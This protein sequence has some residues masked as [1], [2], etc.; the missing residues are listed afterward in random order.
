MRYVY[1]VHIKPYGIGEVKYIVIER[2]DESMFDK[3]DFIHG[4]VDEGKYTFFNRSNEHLW[5]DK[6]KEV[7]EDFD[8]IKNRNEVINKIVSNENKN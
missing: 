5:V 4:R 8:I 2:S 1:K 7:I 3:K 6:L